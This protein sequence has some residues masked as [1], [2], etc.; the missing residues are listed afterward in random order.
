MNFVLVKST[1][2]SDTLDHFILLNYVQFYGEK[3]SSNNNDLVPFANR[4][5][6]GEAFCVCNGLIK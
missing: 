2:I 4:E 3:N 1:K 5:Q 6:S